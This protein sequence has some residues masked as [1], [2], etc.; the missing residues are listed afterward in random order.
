MEIRQ[1]P[2]PVEDTAKAREIGRRARGLIGMPLERAMRNAADCRPVR[3]VG[4]MRMFFS[5]K[6]R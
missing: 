6:D 4:G 5:Y 2:S 3:P 1:T